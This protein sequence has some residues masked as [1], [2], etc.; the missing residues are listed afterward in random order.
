MIMSENT[1]LVSTNRTA[2]ISVISA[3][4]TLLSFCIAVAPIPLTGW[5]CFPAAGLTGLVAFAAGLISLR[6]IRSS[7]ENGRNYA[8]LGAWIGGL[9]TLASLCAVIVGILWLPVIANVIR[10]LSK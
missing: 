3:L 7:G 9:V 5:V 1:P 4:F 8:L 10:Q 2:I 6:Q